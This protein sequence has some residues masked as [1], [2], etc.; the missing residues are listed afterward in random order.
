MKPL[1]LSMKP[2]LFSS[3]LINPGWVNTSGD[4]VPRQ[5]VRRA[6]R[7]VERNLRA[8]PHTSLYLF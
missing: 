4:E 7:F 3:L 5:E 6:L 1:V 2:V 8:L